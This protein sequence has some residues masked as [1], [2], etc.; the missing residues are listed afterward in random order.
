MKIDLNKI[1]KELKGRGFFHFIE[2]IEKA[3]PKTEVYL[4]G[5]AV[6][7]LIMNRQ[8]TD[9]DFIIRNVP[10]KK[11]E[12][13]LTKLGKVNFVGKTFGVFKLVLKDNPN[14]IDIALPRT[15]YAFGTGGRKDFKVKYNPKL[16]IEDDLSRR[17][18]TI[19]AMALQIT[20][21]PTTSNQFIDPFDGLKD[22]QKKIIKTVGKPEERFKE[23]YSRMLRAVRIACELNYKIETKTWAAIK[24]YLKHLNDQRNQDRVVPYEVVAKE[25][26]KTFQANPERAFDLFEESGLFK[27]LMPEIEKMK[28]C[29]QPPQFHAEGDV[30]IHTKMTLAGLSSKKFKKEFSDEQPNINLIM[31]TL[32]HDI[33]KPPT[34]QTPEKHGVDR[35]RT[36]NHDMIGAKM[37]EKIMT[38]LKLSSPA[39][40]GL[41][42]KKVSWLIRNH[43]VMLQLKNTLQEV[44]PSTL[45]KYF[46][47]Q[48]MPSQ[49]LLKLIFVD[50]SACRPKETWQPIFKDYFNLKRKLTALASLSKKKKTLPPPFLNGHE[51]MEILKINS[52]PLIGKIKDTLR[53]AQL[54]KKVKDRKEARIFVQ[55]N[56]ARRS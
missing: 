16:K 5:G 1:T 34:T 51:I 17:D 28:G 45:E 9:F 42:L 39:N 7:D 32:F 24:K 48:E 36:N 22:L 2:K 38:K 41:D 4:V 18:F 44:K 33:G 43:M 8:T 56:Y 11:L 3:E 29:P 35:I 47:N 20:N 10:V 21:N 49:D 30:F 23:D 50:I 52:S 46:F 25:L 15:D 27:V 55:K 53:T 40:I 19:N 26:L 6:R 54:N 12:N 37:A 13:I 14:G 31:A